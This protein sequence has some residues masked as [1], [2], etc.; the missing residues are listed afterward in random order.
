MQP[1]FWGVS[2][3]AMGGVSDDDNV[4]EGRIH[5]R[6]VR[7]CGNSDTLKGC[8]RFHYSHGRPSGGCGTLR[9]QYDIR[10]A[11]QYCPYPSSLA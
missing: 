2:S 3:I 7:P 9:I 5:D 11:V 4:I 6:H 10:A 1:Y 8:V